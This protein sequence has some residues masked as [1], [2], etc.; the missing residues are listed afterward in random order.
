MS[1][2]EIQLR[3]LYHLCF[4]DDLAFEDAYF[5]RIYSRRHST[6]IRRNGQIVSGLLF[7]ECGVNVENGQDYDV[8]AVYLSGVC[9]HPS[10]RGQGLAGELI[11]RTLK[12]RYREEDGY[13][14]L[15]PAD[16]GLAAYYARLG[17][18]RCF[19]YI[20]ETY[21][22]SAE[23]LALPDLLVGACSEEGLTFADVNDYFYEA[24][25]P[26]PLVYYH[27]SP[28]GLP[29]SLYYTD[30]RMLTRGYLFGDDE[31]HNLRIDDVHLYGGGI[32][33][34]ATQEQEIVAEA[35]A[36]PRE[37]H[38]LVTS[39]VCDNVR[40]RMHMLSL[41]AAHYRLPE[42]RIVRPPRLFT[43][44]NGTP[45]GLEGELAEGQTDG[46]ATPLVP[47]RGHS[48]YSPVRPLGMARLI[49]VDVVAATVAEAYPEIET[50]F[51]LADPLLPENSGTYTFRGDGT[52]YFSKRGKA[53]KV[54]V[55]ELTQ[56][57]IGYHPSA[58]PEAL[59]CFPTGIPYMHT[60]LNK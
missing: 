42:I 11:W 20:E 31:L 21:R 47:R 7:A 48:A 40:C 23:E 6:V 15:I 32:W 50:S 55:E 49:S 14:V 29:S 36:Y 41:L 54:T 2:D 30:M 52:V 22:P 1:E 38:L 53:P 4:G 8:G 51:S 37:G 27:A 57:L 19:D 33:K 26:G 58:L 43:P 17:F 59:R 10:F 16:E 18:V 13:A 39:L 56:A 28:P 44:L 35:I 9:T 12:K 34:I 60:M 46:I 3:H 25:P 45:L 5:R 24:L